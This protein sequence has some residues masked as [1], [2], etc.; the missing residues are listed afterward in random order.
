MILPRRSTPVI[1]RVQP[2]FLSL[3]TCDRIRWIAQQHV[4]EP[5]RVSSAE[6]PLGVMDR[7]FRTSSQVWLSPD[8]APEVRALYLRLARVARV[9][10]THMEDLQVVRYHPGEQFQPHYD[11]L[12]D[13]A[14]MRRVYTLMVYLNGADEMEG[15][16]TVFPRLGRRI[17][18]AKGTL[19]WFRNLDPR[20][21]TA[22]GSLHA[23]ASVRAGVKYV[24]QVWV[25]RD[26]VREA[27]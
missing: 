27:L 20:G 18:P 13:R 25:H 9:P 6:H 3:A 26:P 7:S 15:G 5:S 2:A 14:D 19:V 22:E 17:V 21:R 24:C 8:D 12:P 11:G 10:T 23:G 4:F 1:V 16:E